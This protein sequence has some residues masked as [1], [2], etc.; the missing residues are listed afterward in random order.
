MK[1]AHRKTGFDG[2]QAM[3]LLCIWNLLA[4]RTTHIFIFIEFWGTFTIK[5]FIIKLLDV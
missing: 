3:L 1:G 2:S 4:T 5:M